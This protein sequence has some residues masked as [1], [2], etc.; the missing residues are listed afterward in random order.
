[1]PLAV[2]V[3]ALAA[4]GIFCI[5]SNRK[6]TDYFSVISRFGVG[7]CQ[8]TCTS[9]IYAW[10]QIS[11]ACHDIGTKQRPAQIPSSPDQGLA[12]GTHNSDSTSSNTGKKPSGTIPCGLVSF[13]VKNAGKRI[14]VKG[15]PSKI[16]SEIAQFDEPLCTFSPRNWA[17]RDLF[18]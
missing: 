2:R 4:S 16:M 14:P 18:K 11:I 8:L 12:T 6:V 3:I 15:K 13:L 17:I 10:L 5:S 1:M 9:R 7:R